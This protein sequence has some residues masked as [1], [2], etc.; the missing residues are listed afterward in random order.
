VICIA[1]YAG[2]NYHDGGVGEPPPRPRGESFVDACAEVGEKRW[3]RSNFAIRLNAS[4]WGPGADGKNDVIEPPRC[5][6]ASQIPQERSIPTI[7][8]CSQTPPPPRQGER[9]RE[10]EREKHDGQNTPARTP[11]SLVA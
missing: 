10:R 3:C 9:E 5:I 4:S 1:V 11:T 8:P 7:S 6:W 2:T